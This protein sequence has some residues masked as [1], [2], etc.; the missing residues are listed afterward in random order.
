MPSSLRPDVED[1]SKTVACRGRSPR[2]FFLLVFAL[3]LPFFLA[4]ALI[5][6][7]FLP[8]LPVSALMF[9]C[10][11]AAAL[12]R[13]YGEDRTAGVIG[14]LKRSFDGRRIRAKIWYV[15]VILLR[16]GVMVLSYVLMRRM[17]VPLPA[18]ESTVPAALALFLALF[19]AALGEELGWSGY[20]ID[21]MQERWGAARA[22]V[23]VGLVWV[24]WHIVP[25]L[26]VHRSPA[27]IAWWSLETVA[28]RVLIVW[29]YNNTGKSVFAA[30]LFHTMSNVSWLLFPIHGS[31]YDPRIVGPITAFTAVLVTVVWGP[32]T[33]RGR[34]EE[35]PECRGQSARSR[36]VTGES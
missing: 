7:P 34:G 16:P 19:I 1:S 6:R 3:S 30:T 9:V 31:Y 36:S 13:V 11:M 35:L 22:G 25:L 27:W 14:L 2:A 8:G 28:T 33:L 17:G 15:P 10:P 24:A 4:G 23:L 12:I 21:P 32:R 20:V 18:P 29:L 26:Q 5:R